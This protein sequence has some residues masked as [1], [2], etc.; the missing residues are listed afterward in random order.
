MNSRS[1]EF[2]RTADLAKMSRPLSG[3]L[4]PPH[5]GGIGAPSGRLD[6]LKEFY[7]VSSGS[8][9]Y[10]MASTVGFGRLY[11][12]IKQSIYCEHAADSWAAVVSAGIYPIVSPPSGGYRF[13]G[14]NG[15]VVMGTGCYRKSIGEVYS[16]PFFFREHQW[17]DAFERRSLFG[18]TMGLCRVTFGRLP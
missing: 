18:R 16:V 2:H 17:E 10:T 8:T 9:G 15:T 5:L 1:T 6:E 4:Q 12:D 13:V 3:D 14:L 7:S 11:R